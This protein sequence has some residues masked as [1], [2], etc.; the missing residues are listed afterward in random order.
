M[1]K[2]LL[3]FG[4]RPEAIK[5]APLYQEFNKNS[6]F[7]D[8]KVC[9]TAQHRQML[10]QVLNFLGIKPDYD[11]NLM[12]NNQSLFDITTGVLRGLEKVLKDYKPDLVFVQG[13]TTSAFVGALSAFYMKIKVAHLEAGLRSYNKY[14][15]FPEE[16]NRVL[17]GHLADYHFAPTIK[18][19]E[20]LQKEGVKENVWVVGNTVIDALFWGLEIIEKN[21]NLKKEI[22]SF[23]ERFLDS[24]EDK[25]ILV[26]G[27]RRESFGEGFENICKA[28]KE[29]AIQ[30]PEIKIIYPVHLNPNV[31]EPV[32]R[33]LNGIANIYLIEPLEYPYLIW[34]MSKSYL[35][36]T[37]SGGIQEE[38]PSLG[39]P[40]LVMRDVT[41]RIEGIEAGTAKLV[42]TKKETIF[43]AVQSL[44]ENQ[45]EYQKMSKAVN[46][47]GDGLASKRIVDIIRDNI[48]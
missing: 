14:A 17:I 19:K 8:V 47:Y 22:E 10:D 2:I 21:I 40:V 3:I 13:D 48:N 46:P 24:N 6:N 18:A 39:K 29:I 4:T 23:F 36:L 15:P 5:F 27:H 9:I 28:L 32:N 12:K 35:V 30:F 31:R 7:F 37:D 33:I 34:L 42:G 38:A 43:K 26:T 1:R 25:V 45:S 11:L 20:N 16:I 41:E 44:I